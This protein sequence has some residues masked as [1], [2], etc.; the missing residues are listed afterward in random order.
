MRA[1]ETVYSDLDLPLLDSL[2]PTQPHR[3]VD[4]TIFDAD[5][6]GMLPET[7]MTDS[8]VISFE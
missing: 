4:L 1:T 8:I 7:N 5:A 2:A 3:P 6:Q